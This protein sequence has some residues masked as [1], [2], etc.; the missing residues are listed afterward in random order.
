MMK[1]FLLQF[2]VLQSSILILHATPGAIFDYYTTS[3]LILTKFN[4]CDTTFIII[5]T[6]TCTQSIKARHQSYQALAMLQDSLA[7]VDPKL[8]YCSD[9]RK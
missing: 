3:N 5:I 6:Y 2:I 1:L 9:Y 7:Q 4:S 8:T